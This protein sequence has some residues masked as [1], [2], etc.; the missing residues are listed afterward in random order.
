MAAHRGLLNFLDNRNIRVIL[1]EG[2]GLVLNRIIYI[3]AFVLF[4]ISIPGCYTGQ[5]GGPPP[6]YNLEAEL[7]GG[8][9]YLTWNS[10]PCDRYHV[11]RSIAIAGNWTEIA[12]T[13]Q[14]QSY[15]RD[16][17]V[18]PGEMFYYRVRSYDDSFD[19]PYSSYSN[20]AIIYIE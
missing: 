16:E 12:T 20:E 17:T 11:E 7:D 19:P 15:F 8:A 6:P 3:L 14:N 18:Y 10:V 5:N 2:A 4:T 13:P 1:Y 9:V